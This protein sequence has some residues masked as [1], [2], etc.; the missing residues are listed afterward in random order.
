MLELSELQKM[1]KKL[2]ITQ[3]ELAKKA[4]VS[5]SLIAK[6][7]SGKI[8]PSYTNAKKVFETLTMLDKTNELTCDQIMFSKICYIKSSD[9]L[10]E[11]ILKM[12]RKNISQ[13]PVMKH[14]KIVGY[15]SETV[16]LD[17]ILEGDS[18]TLK[19]ADV[20]EP[21]PPIVPPN[22]SQGIVANLLKHF[23]FVL[24]EDKG[25]LVGIITKSDLLRVV[26]K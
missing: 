23:P 1:R 18:Q 17:N 10:K 21:S 8:D 3:S 2:G 9:T 20:M 25:E 22:T 19:V 26:Y 7:E 6:I 11:A 4:T 12:R 16:L 5:Q 15:I 24:V 13:M 14:K